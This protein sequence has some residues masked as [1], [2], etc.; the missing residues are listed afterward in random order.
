MTQSE[1]M[2]LVLLYA[3][4]ELGGGEKRRIV[5]QHK[6]IEDIGTNTTIMI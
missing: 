5:L 1:Q 6:T 2:K 3:I 4:N